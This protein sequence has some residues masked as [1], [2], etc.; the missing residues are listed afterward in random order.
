MNTISYK[1]IDTQIQLDKLEKG[2]AESSFAA[3]DIEG[4]SMHSYYERVCLMQISIENGSFIVD[5]LKDIDFSGF[6][7]TLEQKLLIL[8][9]GDYDLRMLDKDF[10][11]KPKFKIFDTQQAASLAGIQKTSLSELLKEF[12]GLSHPKDQQLSDWTKRPLTEKQLSYAAADTAYLKPLADKLTELLD[13]MGRS[14]WVSQSMKDR[15][16]NTPK[17]K[18]KSSREKWRVKGY[19]ALEPAGLRFLREIWELRE[20]IA[21]KIDLPPFKVMRS[22]SMIEL[23]KKLAEKPSYSLAKSKFLPKTCKGEFYGVLKKRIEHARKLPESRWPERF[24]KRGKPPSHDKALT[25]KLRSFV[26]QAAEERGIDPSIL[27]NKAGIEEISRRKPQ[28]EAELR[29]VLQLNDWQFD[30]LEAKFISIIQSHTS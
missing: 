15:A 12:L 30:I 1:Y 23:S 2:I 18:V 6:T 22:S 25:K 20:D 19:S 4:N 29:E 8:H 24:V 5:T 10:G 26:L 7:K 9:G 14:E 13:S 28:T 21:A 27:V 16:K 11:F 3:L 17:Y